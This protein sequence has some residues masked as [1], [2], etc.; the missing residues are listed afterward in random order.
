MESNEEKKKQ[1]A[2][3]VNNFYG[4][5]NIKEMVVNGDFVH[6]EQGGIGKQISNGGEAPQTQSDKDI[7]TAIEELLQATDDKGTPIFR[8]KKQWWAVYRVLSTFC[9]YPTKMTAFQEK[10]KE[11]GVDVVDGQRDLAYN[12]LK[13]P[14]IEVPQIATCSPSTWHTMKDI[15]E[16]YNQQYVVADF[17]MLKLG[18]KS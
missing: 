11:L 13:A 7:K 2:S 16:N 14:T 10:M 3:V 9:D 6:V 4:G 5:I 15:N 1:K 18:I 17:L 8:N 12:S